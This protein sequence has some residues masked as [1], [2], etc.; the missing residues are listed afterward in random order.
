[1]KCVFR[2]SMSLLSYLRL[3]PWNK[4]TVLRSEM[5]FFA[6]R[7]I[8]RPLGLDPFT[9]NAVA[10]GSQGL[11]RSVHREMEEE[12][13]HWEGARGRVGCE[14]SKKATTKER[15]WMLREPISG[16]IP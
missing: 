13:K 12:A 3:T 7:A 15:F 10:H 9:P 1:M 2:L 4:S 11:R 14:D 16:V 6:R 5:H 8:D